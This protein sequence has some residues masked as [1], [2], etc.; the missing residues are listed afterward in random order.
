MFNRLP[1][2]IAEHEATGNIA[3]IYHDIRRTFR[4]TGV[5]LNFRTWAA[6]ERFF[7]AMWASASPIA[8]TVAFEQAADSVRTHAAALATTL[9][10]IKAGAESKLGDSQRFQIAR[11]LGLYHYVNPKLLVFTVLVR[12]AL[13]Q[14]SRRTPTAPQGAAHLLVGGAA[15]RMAPM[16]M[17]DEQSADR[18]LR[19]VFRDIKKTLNL[20]SV[21]SDYRTLGLWPAYLEAGWTQLKPLVKS[22]AYKTGSQQISDEAARAAEA[23][24]VPYGLDRRRL[25][26]LGESHERILDVTTRFE[27]L[28][29]SLIL[30]IALWSREWVSDDE[31]RASPYPWEVSA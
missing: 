21:N 28:L 18:R 30:N 26:Q 2:P 14:E 27:R 7:A 11:A 16:E 9:P 23:L 10:R 5:N 31:L 3:E 12:H 15:P 19:R 17:I 25:K 6:F 24:P 4:V 1:V 29:P 20:S 22:E 8:Q 13:E